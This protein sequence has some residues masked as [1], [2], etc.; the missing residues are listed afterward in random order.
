MKQRP[1]TTTF[2]S[3]EHIGLYPA[4]S[5]EGKR[6]FKTTYRIDRDGN[7][8]QVVRLRLLDDRLREDIICR[9]FLSS[10]VRWIIK[11]DVTV[12]FQYRDAPWDFRID[13]GSDQPFNLEITA[14]AEDQAQF[15][16]RSRERRLG[17]AIER[18]TIPM[19]LLRKLHK[20]AP[21][22]RAEVLIERANVL[23]IRD[24]DEVENPWRADMEPI[25]IGHSPMSS[26]S[27]LD[28]IVEAITTKAAKRHADKDETILLIDNW[29]TTFGIEDLQDAAAGFGDLRAICP[30][31]EVWFYTGYYSDDDGGN[32]E[33]SLTPVL[34]PERTAERFNTTLTDADITPNAAGL[35]FSGF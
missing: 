26:R 17:R 9:H 18:Q 28:H 31:K 29:S 10:Y 11:E 7:V 8:M 27:L 23:G 14:V 24:D 12:N 34:L 2:R 22:E 3:A 33:W 16:R 35:V 13:L 15:E 5:L 1:V 25:W 19:S 32:A 4:K 30:F 21:C 6:N 20:D